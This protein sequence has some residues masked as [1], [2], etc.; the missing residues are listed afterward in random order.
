MRLLYGFCAVC[1]V[2]VLSALSLGCQDS[3]ER[4]R[5]VIDG[6][7]DDTDEL[8]VEVIQQDAGSI[9]ARGLQGAELRS[10]FD[11]LLSSRLV[12]TAELRVAALD[13]RDCRL[14]YAAISI[15]PGV[16]Q[17]R[18]ALQ[19]QRSVR[20]TLQVAQSGGGTIEL[21]KKPWTEKTE[22]KLY[23]YRAGASGEA[24]EVGRS[25]TL[26]ATPNPDSYFVGWAGACREAGSGDCTLPLGESLTA[27]NAAFTP[28]RPC[29]TSGFCWLNPLPSGFEL[30]GIHG[31][32]ATDIWV[33]GAGGTVMHYNG[34]AWAP[35][36][37]VTDA[38]LYGVWGKSTDDLWIVGEQGTL[39]RWNGLEL[40][41]VSRPTKAA[42]TAVWG[43]SNGDVWIGGEGLIWRCH[44]ETDC[45]AVP[46][47]PWLAGG[48]AALLTAIQ[49][50]S[51]SEVYFGGHFGTLLRWDGTSFLKIQTP[52]TADITG[53][54]SPGT[55]EDLWA[56]SGDGTLWHWRQG[57]FT[58]VMKHSKRLS[59]V[60]GVSTSAGGAAREVWTFSGDGLAWRIRGDQAQ[61]IYTGESS[62]VLA[63]HMSSLGDLWG[64]GIGGNLL[65]WDGGQFVQA[66]SGSRG[67][68][69]GR[70]G[71]GGALHV[72]LLDQTVMHFDN[73]SWSGVDF[74]PSGPLLALHGFPGG[75]LWGL[76]VGGFLYRRSA[77][78]W[79]LQDQLGGS[80]FRSSLYSLWGS[81][82]DDM[83]AVGL[84]ATVAHIQ[85]GKFTAAVSV[86]DL[87]EAPPNP[88]FP[89]DLFLWGVWGSGP[90]DIWA[91]G[92]EG[93]IVHLDGTR[94]DSV[95][96]YSVG[97]V[98]PSLLSIW[99][100]G[101][102][103]VWA[104]GTDGAVLRYQG[105]DWQTFLRPPCVSTGAQ[106][107]TVFYDVSGTGPNDVWLAGTRPE[108]GT[109]A[110]LYHFDGTR[111]CA[112]RGLP[113]RL[114]RV[115][116]DAGGVYVAGDGGAI[117]YAQGKPRC[118][119]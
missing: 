108:S 41:D 57:K 5:V 50:V 22:G 28:R 13:R 12:A 32:S 101:P 74:I 37:P 2:F 30:N 78:A 36:I 49:G 117:L 110:S 100:S 66:G 109:C 18:V 10:E 35:L 31:F 111:F 106:P 42:L 8:R 68:V 115:W 9:G 62:D 48:R 21:V 112:V 58:A 45:A 61:P 89:A 97:S 1:C 47:G 99:G 19:D 73:A 56:A 63:A 11:I 87:L 46:V 33:V 105:T 80:F 82:A 71:I 79:A 102:S 67:Q 4:V 95:T 38:N 60:T 93:L 85:A 16:G 116:A 14:A 44:T 52:N 103:D 59:A 86:Q 113:A 72:S 77:G 24:V 94:L 91:V 25:L 90:R 64:V 104:V 39:L 17:V 51:P 34:Q 23:V 55:S 76:Q 81:T 26:R 98:T 40:R 92:D 119:S 65:H 107:A 7:P 27:V 20:C 69:V 84:R 83:W 53:L 6:L 70:F 114:S 96:P 118:G 75:D 29:T 3:R 88:K 54:W 43:A 15:F